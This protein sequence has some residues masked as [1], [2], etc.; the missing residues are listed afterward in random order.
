MHERAN[1]MKHVHGGL[2]D[3]DPN[4]ESQEDQEDFHESM[5]VSEPASTSH[6]QGKRKPDKMIAQQA[7]TLIAEQFVKLTDAIKDFEATKLTIL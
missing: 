5:G 2:D 6:I 3:D 4:T 7:I 1:V